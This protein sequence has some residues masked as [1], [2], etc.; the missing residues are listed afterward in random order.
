MSR[1]QEKEERRKRLAQLAG[2][3]FAEKQVAQ[4]KQE[5]S[6]KEVSENVEVASFK[7]KTNQERKGNSGF[8]ITALVLGIIGVLGCLIPIVNNVSFIFGILAFIFGLIAILRAKKTNVKNGLGKAGFVLS[9]VTMIGVFASQALYSSVLEKASDEI[10]KN[11][12]SVSDELP[13]TAQ[14]TESSQ[15]ESEEYYFRDNVAQT[16]KAKIEIVNHEV[17]QPNTER[18][19]GEKPLIVFT[20]KVTNTSGEDVKAS[21]EWSSAFDA[22][23]DNDPNRENKLEV[24]YIY[25]LFDDKYNQGNDTIKNGGTV[26][27]QEGYELTDETTPVTLKCKATMFGDE[28]GSQDFAIK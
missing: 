1:E 4:K 7:A 10:E 6:V 9:I 23:Q 3:E 22:Y 11:L 12:S 25:G 15:E 13:K 28:I 8:A 17:L 21:W 19:S 26:E 14:T 20:Y 16:E 5:K 18:N 27:H 24:S 2:E